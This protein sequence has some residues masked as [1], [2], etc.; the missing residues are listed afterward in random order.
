[1]NMISVIETDDG[2][3]II[4]TREPIPFMREISTKGVLFN[5]FDECHIV[6]QTNGDYVLIN[7]QLECWRSAVRIGPR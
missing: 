1:M 5:D 7:P 4:T 6:A 3:I 2:R